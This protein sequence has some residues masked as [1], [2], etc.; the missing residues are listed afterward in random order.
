MGLAT[1]VL[2]VSALVAWLRAPPP[3]LRV[4]VVGGGPTGLVSGAGCLVVFCSMFTAHTAITARE[5]GL[6][7]T[8][9]EKRWQY[10]RRIW[11]DIQGK[12]HGQGLDVLRS[13]GLEQELGP[14]ELHHFPQY[15]PATLDLVVVKCSALERFLKARALQLGVKCAGFPLF[16]LQIALATVLTLTLAGSSLWSTRGWSNYLTMTCSSARTASRARCIVTARPSSHLCGP[17][18]SSQH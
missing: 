9:V 13:W 6:D 4:L 16:S 14:D 8:I 15:D 3:A 5:A 12:P 2:L 11:F 1:I 10:T 17:P 18:P 7:V